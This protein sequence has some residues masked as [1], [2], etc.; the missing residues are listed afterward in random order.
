MLVSYKN[1]IYFL[2]FIISILLF[3]LYPK[4]YSYNAC[5]FALVFFAAFVIPF[6]KDI[7]RGNYF[8]YHF[9]FFVSMFFCNYAYAILF[10]PTDLGLMFRALGL[11]FNP[12]VM[13]KCMMLSNVAALAYIFG[14]RLIKQHPVIAK[15]DTIRLLPVLKSVLVCINYALLCI[16]FITLRTYIT[17]GIYISVQGFFFVLFIATLIVLIYVGFDEVTPRNFYRKFDKNILIMISIFVLSLLRISDRGPVIMV[18]VAFLTMYFTRI[19]KISFFEI[20]FLMLLGAVVLA[21][22]AFT[23][24]YEASDMTV[25]D[26]GFERFRFNFVGL[27]LIRTNRNLFQMYDYVKQNGV[28]YGTTSATD[29]FMIVPLFA[30]FLNRFG[31]SFTG[32]STLLNSLEFIGDKPFGVG[33]HM[34]GDLYLS[35]GV[36]GVIIFPLILGLF[37][38]K[39]ELMFLNK[40]SHISSIAYLCFM[41]YAIYI[42]RTGFFVG[43]H[44]IILCIILFKLCQCLSEYLCADLKFK[45]QKK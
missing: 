2:G 8:N 45:N 37:V 22:I 25:L 15:K 41:S 29:F 17:N 27:D 32:S 43:F 21:F 13:P 39:T 7:S 19:R 24:V 3:F 20:L 28:T 44:R 42:Q 14:V 1:I 9:L 11:S 38:R 36:I 30:G 16:F 26:R 5:L 10:Y 23:R 6:I 18:A 4:T 33:S 40:K 12:N 34:V 31:I 35:F